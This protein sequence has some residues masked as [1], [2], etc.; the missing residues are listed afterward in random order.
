MS[1][2]PRSGR[3]EIL[4]CQVMWEPDSKKNTLMDRFRAAVSAACGLALGE[5]ACGPG[6]PGHLP[7]S[8]GPPDGGGPCSWGRDAPFSWA[9]LAGSL[10]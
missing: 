9:F 4:E 1:K 2:E 6:L 3:G 8:E 7:R 5:C 10:S